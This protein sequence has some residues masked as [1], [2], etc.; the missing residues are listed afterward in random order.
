MTHANG[1]NVELFHDL[2]ILQ[3][4]L[5]SQRMAR[6][7]M[8]LVN[9]RT[10]DDDRRAV[11]PDL[12]VLH[13]DLAETGLDS[14]HLDGLALGVLEGDGDVV[15]A[16]EL[17]APQFRA[18]YVLLEGHLLLLSGCDCRDRQ[19]FGEQGLA[20]LF[21]ERHLDSIVVRR[22]FAEVAD[23][24]VHVEDTVLVGLVEIADG[25]EVLDRHFRPG[26]QVNITLDAGQPPEV[27][28]L[29]PASATKTIDIHCNLVISFLY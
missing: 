14:G 8:V 26:D 22:L 3:S 17:G 16:R 28:V 10:P 4:G 23:S 20:L 19:A 12:P 6:F 29:Q 18:A 11:N 9:V 2:D 21:R 15:E 25:E 27:L 1:V 24:H 7:G 13:L 5:V